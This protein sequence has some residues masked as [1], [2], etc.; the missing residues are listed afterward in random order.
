[1]M[2]WFYKLEPDMIMALKT[3]SATTFRRCGKTTA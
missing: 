1:M 3:L 2:A